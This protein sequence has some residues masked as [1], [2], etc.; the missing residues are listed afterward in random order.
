MY[1][2]KIEDKLI[3]DQVPGSKLTVNQ[4][5][6]IQNKEHVWN[7]GL[8][9]LVGHSRRIQSNKGKTL[10]QSTPWRHM[11]GEGVKVQLHK[12]I[13]FDRDEWYTWHPR[14]VTPGKN[15]STRWIED[16]LGPVTRLDILENR[17]IS[18]SYR[19]LNPRML[20]H[21][22]VTIAAM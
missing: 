2:H 9:N 13:T 16:C 11:G 19:G 5:G 12:F 22:L 14:H 4:A 18:C 15:T 3:G 6:C 1:L 8:A 10:S 17:K 7:N 21:S 20:S